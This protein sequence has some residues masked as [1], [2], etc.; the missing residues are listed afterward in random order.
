MNGQR[1]EAGAVI[2]GYTLE[3][4]IHQ[5]SMATLWRVSAPGTRRW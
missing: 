2:D 5:G 1:I 3:E 4:R